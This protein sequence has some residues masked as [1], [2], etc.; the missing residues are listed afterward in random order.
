MTVNLVEFLHHPEKPVWLMHR[1]RDGKPCYWGRIVRLAYKWRSRWS[2]TEYYLCLDCDQ[3]G[4]QREAREWERLAALQA[5]EE[6]GAYVTLNGERTDEPVR[7]EELPEGY[8]LYLSKA[9]FDPRGTDYFVG[10]E[11]LDPEPPAT[12]TRAWDISPKFNVA[13]TRDGDYVLVE[14]K[15]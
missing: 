1:R 15:E 4:T 11:D 12:W 2:H 14:A 13:E 5:K 3:V 9:L 7:L 6:A 10:P 8:C